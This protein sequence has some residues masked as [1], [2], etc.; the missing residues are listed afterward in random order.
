MLKHPLVNTSLLGFKKSC[1]DAV[2][3]LLVGLG[4]LPRLVDLQ[5]ADFLFLLDLLRRLL[6]H[7]FTLGL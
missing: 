7:I 2:N 1:V 4:S 5:V 6:V 3:L